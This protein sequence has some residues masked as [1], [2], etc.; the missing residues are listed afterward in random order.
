M[1]SHKVTARLNKTGRLIELW[2]ED[3][4]CVGSGTG[5]DEAQ[6]HRIYKNYVDVMGSYPVVF[7]E[8]AV[9]DFEYD[10]HPDRYDWIKQ[11]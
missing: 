8:D 4:I 7:V 3:G 9:F 1:K 5:M 6:S 10:N 2:T 11:A